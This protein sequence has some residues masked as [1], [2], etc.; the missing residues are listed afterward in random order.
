MPQAS[1][2]ESESQRP[3]WRARLDSARLT[4]RDLA[5]KL[6][7]A[8]SSAIENS[9]D[10]FCPDCAEAVKAKARVCRYCGFRFAPP[11]ESP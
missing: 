7:V 6:A 2:P 5:E 10:K 9:G 4:A 11:P 3:D 8:A 1:E